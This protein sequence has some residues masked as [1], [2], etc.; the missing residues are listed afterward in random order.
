MDEDAVVAGG[1]P[2]H[3]RAFG[4][5][6]DANLD[7]VHHHMAPDGIH[8]NCSPSDNIAL[9][10][11]A[12]NLAGSVVLHTHPYEAGV[13]HSLAEG[14][15]HHEGRLAV[16]A[17]LTGLNIHSNDPVR[18][19]QIDLEAVGGG[20]VVVRISERPAA[21]QA[22]ICHEVAVGVGG[23][24]RSV[25]GIKAH[26]DF[27]AVA[28]TVAIGIPVAG[29]R[30][31]GKLLKI[32][33]SVTIEVGILGQNIRLKRRAGI[34]ASLNIGIRNWSTYEDI[35]KV[36]FLSLEIARLR[37]IVDVCLIP[38]VVFPAI[39][40]AV[41]IGILHRGIHARIAVGAGLRRPFGKVLVPLGIMAIGLG[42][43]LP[44]LGL[45]WRIRIAV[46][47]IEI[48][49][50]LRHI[51]RIETVA[52]AANLHA[53][54]EC[55]ANWSV[56]ISLAAVNG[57][58]EVLVRIGGGEIHKVI[59]NNLLSTGNELDEVAAAPSLHRKDVRDAVGIDIA[60]V[61]AHAPLA[62]EDGL[63]FRIKIVAVLR[64]LV[65]KVHAACSNLARN[66]RRNRAENR[67]GRT[68]IFVNG[69]ENP[70][71]EEGVLPVRLLEIHIGKGII[72]AF[73][74]RNVDASLCAASSADR[75]I[76]AVIKLTIILRIIHL[77]AVCIN[78]Y[79]RLLG[80]VPP[81]AEVIGA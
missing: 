71:V 1:Y 33:E 25:E 42:K 62:G 41:A 73:F 60:E 17:E 9:E 6:L 8:R 68:A 37:E 13:L 5:I 72:I 38:E 54:S 43:L 28:H 24:I 51:K 32:G 7:D 22:E 27:P 75:H 50:G 55:C 45:V 52:K 74:P 66:F 26:H 35:T 44:S 65:R 56:A 15:H 69:M 20:S 53:G 78:L 64:L 39:R 61:V 18:D 21:A 34:E 80:A 40:E 48:G 46:N 79:S 11:I 23:L 81:E 36:E 63:N 58:E 67:V 31:D 57:R 29:I 77:I 19:V 30:A 4:K 12:D 47:N 76:V 2:G 49:I 16:G 14:A 10:A 70:A 59:L 3:F